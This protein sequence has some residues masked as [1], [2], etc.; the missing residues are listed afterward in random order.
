MKLPRMTT[1]RWMIAVAALSVTF[2]GYREA[3]RL[4]RS[5]EEFLLRAA[6]H[7]A[8][9]TYYRRLISSSESS[10]IHKKIAARELAAEELMSTAQ[11]ETALESP[12]ELWAG[13]A[14]GHSTQTEEAGHDRFREAQARAAAMAVRARMIMDDYLQRQ[15]EY[16]RRQ[17][18]YHAA[19]GRK[20]TAA[21]ARPWLPV[22]PDPPKPK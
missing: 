4:K 17:A 3:I 2:G 1:R 18:E 19:L 8:G 22:A 21:A 10:I 6:R 9:E 16:H 13:P 12:V 11:N 20:Y 14:E 15:V 7:C 5:R